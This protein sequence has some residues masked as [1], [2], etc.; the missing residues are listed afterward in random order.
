MGKPVGVFSDCFGRVQ[1]M[2]AVLPLVLWYIG[3]QTEEA[4]E[5]KI[6]EQARK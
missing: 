1:L 2:W 6:E 4:R 5:S 3:N